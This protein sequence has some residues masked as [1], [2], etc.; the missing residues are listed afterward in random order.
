MNPKMILFNMLKNDEFSSW[1]PNANIET[2][3]LQ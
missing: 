2:G 3:R 1:D